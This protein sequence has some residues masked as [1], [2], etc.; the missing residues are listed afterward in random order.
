[1][2]PPG[3][4]VPAYSDQVKCAPRALLGEGGVGYLPVEVGHVALAAVLV[5][6]DF[7][8]PAAA[9]APGP[10][11]DVGGA[12][13]DLT[14]DGLGGEVVEGEGLG[15]AVGGEGGVVP[16]A[17]VDG[18]VALGGADVVDPPLEAELAVV[19]DI[20]DGVE[21][22]G[23]GGADCGAGRDWLALAGDED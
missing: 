22:A 14:G 11:V 2:P 7:V 10:D 8:G 12:E 17:V 5:L 1:M 20:Q 16:Q 4:H 9:E 19:P 18:G 15:V 23:D 3:A 21:R 6:V 13:A